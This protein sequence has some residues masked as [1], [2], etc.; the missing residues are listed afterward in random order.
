MTKQKSK[1]NIF[2]YDFLRVSWFRAPLKYADETFFVHLHT[3]SVPLGC[4]SAGCVAGHPAA[5][6][7]C[8]LF[9]IIIMPLIKKIDRY[10]LSQ[11]LPLLAGAFCICLFVFMMQFTWRKIDDLIGKGI[12]ADILA[13][14]FG[15]MAVS[16]TPMSLPLAVLLASL[17]TFGN[18]GEK[19]ELL[20]M[21][22]A[23]VPLVR[24][25][26]PVMV[27]VSLLTVGSFFFQN[28]IA[29]RAQVNMAALFFSMKQAQPAVEIPVGVFYNEVPGL[30]LYVGRK[31]V[32]TGMLYDVVI[33][34]TDQG[35]DRSQIVLADSAHLETTA[36]KTHLRLRLWN[37]VQYGS[38][39]MQG[40]TGGQAGNTPY[41]R[42]PFTTMNYLIDFDSN[43]A[44]F[45][46][47]LLRD[48]PQAKDMRQI[49]ADIDS[50]RLSLDSLGHTRYIEDRARWYALPV[51][52]RKDSL[53][54]AA[55][56]MRSW[57]K[58]QDAVQP[59]RRDLARRR[60]EQTIVSRRAELEWKRV[61]AEE[62]ERFVRKHQVEWHRKMTLALSCIL[63]FFIGAPLGAIIRKGGLGMPAVVSVLIFIFYYII[64]TSG[65]KMARDGSWDMIYG[66]W[67]SSAVL[68]PVGVM[69]T[70]KANKDSAV[71]NAEL[72][73]AVLRRLVGLRE[74]RHLTRKEVVISE[75][76]VPALHE[77]LRSLADRCGRYLAGQHLLRLPGYLGTFFRRPLVADEMESIA[78]ELEAIVEEL[79]NSRDGRA[80]ERLNALPVILVHAHLAPFSARWAN[81][82]AGVLLPFGLIL[83]LRR[84]RF[85]RR[86]N[87]D[88]K[89]MVKAIGDIC[90]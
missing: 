20:S 87:K 82:V 24:I 53:R 55:L 37:G 40:A 77:R 81:V 10:I 72:Y 15:H 49:S 16:L 63:F 60:A 51:I 12:S 89:Q 80:V 65:M 75:P 41:V 79:S 13:E 32:S 8:A 54:I 59:Q 76:D 9:A 83:W 7:R 74:H 88:L 71:F 39:M 84:W 34:R 25:M 1:K 3:R 31:D 57:Q 66:M 73:V 58:A 4:R 17:I 22:A 11:F 27:L 64:D 6:L 44:L 47:D 43:F 61:N 46:K 68:L 35:F 14:L 69:L 33:Y 28:T 70:V 23:G 38:P 90:K 42:M 45:D 5:S 30:N 21:K 85:R 18:M 19:L 52:P 29:P 36:D 86:L 48:T 62:G 50:A 56:P 67:V 2:V 26:R 78:A